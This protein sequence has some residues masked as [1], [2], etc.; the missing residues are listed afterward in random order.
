[1][2]QM[3]EQWD[4]FA[5]E[6]P[7]Y[8]IDASREDWTE[9]EFLA[10]GRKTVTALL[11]FAG[12][13]I[14]PG[15]ALE[16]GCGLGRHSAALAERFE[17]VEAVDISPEMVRRARALVSAPNVGFTAVSGSDLREFSD[18][19]FDLV[20]SFLVLQHIAS[21]DVIAGY[22][23]EIAR[24]LRGRALLQF[25]TRPEGAVTRL[26]E[27]LPDAVLPRSRRRFMRR[28][29]RDA[30]R[31]RDLIA[32]AGLAVE[33]ERGAGG[34]DHLLLLAKMQHA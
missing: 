19:S 12:E 34:P 22:L 28:Y 30:G 6:D 17:R 29:R 27:R 2:A 18:D 13:E 8:F 26:Y 4:R 33:R 32:S 14:E 9:A 16:I 7:M 23:H 31:V 11:E 3:R 10:S 21:E 5:R 15:T 25:D 20:L 24:V 1:M